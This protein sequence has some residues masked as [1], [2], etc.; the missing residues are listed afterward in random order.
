MCVYVG[1]L[2]RQHKDCLH[3]EATRAEVEKVLQTGSQKVHD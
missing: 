2:V 1:Y 3:C